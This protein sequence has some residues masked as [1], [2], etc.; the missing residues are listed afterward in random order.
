MASILRRGQG[1]RARIIRKGYAPLTQS[2]K[3]LSEAQKWA[4]NIEV[5][6]DRGEIKPRAKPT[7]RTAETVLFRL[8]AEH[9]VK[10]HTPLK[11]NQR[12]EAGIIK[13]LMDRWGQKPVGAITTKLVSD[14][15]D[16]LLETGRSGATVGHY[17]NAVSVIYQMLGAEWGL[18][19]ANPT[20]G[21]RR[22]PQNPA[23]Y[24]RLSKEAQELLKDCCAQ[25]SEPTLLPI[26]RLA[27]E[28]GMRR[29]EL[30]S[31]T[32]N[33]ID[34]KNRRINIRQTKNG[35][36]RVIPTS[37]RTIAIVS[38]L[39]HSANGRLFSV[40]AESLRKHFERTVKRAAASW[41]GD[42]PNPFE[43]LR[44][45]DLRH[46]ALSQLSDKGLNVIELSQF[47]GHKTLSMLA[48]Y[49]H[50]DAGAIL[51]KINST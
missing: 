11:R 47:S 14:L 20:R 40:G 50:P 7:E 22:P 41:T 2:F 28:T 9:Y 49:T 31:L 25:S 45:H 42:L 34:L 37:E 26:V 48:R 30:L 29:G 46:E 39:L 10:T 15:R 38:P 21:V 13:L 23:R 5:A 24:S 6:I 19:V 32:R 12:S 43:T 8:A 3:S 4:R 33:D 36:P 44:F 27:L 51:K 18:M 17:L 35:S 1:Y 16:E